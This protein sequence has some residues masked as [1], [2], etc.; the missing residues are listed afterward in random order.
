MICE[1]GQ[2]LL[3]NIQNKEQHINTIMQMT[4]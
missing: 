1:I 4:I 3:K 2:L